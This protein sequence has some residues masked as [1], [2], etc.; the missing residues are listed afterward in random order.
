MHIKNDFF[1]ILCI[2]FFV[3][4]LFSSCNDDDDLK[5]QLFE[6]LW[7]QEQVTED[8]Q[9]LT[10]SEKEKNLQLLIEGNGIY[11]TFT[12]DG[13]TS[14]QQYGAWTTTDGKWIDFN[15]DIWHVKVMPSVEDDG[16]IKNGE[17][18]TNHVLSRFTVLS[19]TNEKMEIRMKTYVGEIKYSPVFVAHDRPQITFDNIDEL[20][21]EYKTLKT[22]I[23]TFKKSSNLQY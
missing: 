16:T 13:V 4:I 6:G 23:F 12:T 9:V 20:V 21:K 19:L 18:G 3:P 8:G 22:Y 14:I 7:I 1:K 11:R 17:W 15:T 2:I 5:V 10:L